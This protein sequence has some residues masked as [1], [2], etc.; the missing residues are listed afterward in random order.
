MSEVDDGDVE[1]RGN[2]AGAFGTGVPRTGNPEGR[3]W[4]I[5]A[6]KRERI[7]QHMHQV[8]EILGMDLQDDS[9]AET[10]EA[11]RQDV[12]IFRLDY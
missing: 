6:E 11:D 2:A 9:L 8:M 10:I 5:G 3:E 4:L 12:S 7:Q 1:Q